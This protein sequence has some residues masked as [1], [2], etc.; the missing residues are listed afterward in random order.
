MAVLGFIGALGLLC[1]A[2]LGMVHEGMA[3]MSAALRSIPAAEGESLAWEA[4]VSMAGPW[5]LD[6]TAS[7]PGVDEP[8]SAEVIFTAAEE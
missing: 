3:P 4:D 5:T 6:V 7:V 1:S 8:V 2:R